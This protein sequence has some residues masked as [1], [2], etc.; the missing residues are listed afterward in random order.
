[1]TDWRVI[2]SRRRTVALQVTAEGEVLVRAPLRAPEA[3]LR[4]FVEQHRDWIA[5]QQTRQAEHRQAYPPLTETET[6]ALRRQAKKTLPPLVEAW[7]R[8]MG[9]AP[10]GVRITAA[11]KRFG[12]C[13]AENRLCFSLYLMR[14]PPQAVE[15]VVV[16]ELAHIRHKS[17]SAAFY[18][19]VERWLPDYRQRQAL[20]RK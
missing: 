9:V 4:R 17:H 19:E 2:R 3:A 12:S 15:A 14:Y 5:R 16:H 13:S 11:K 8:R 1:M 18:A 10:A 20:L 6:E 7:A